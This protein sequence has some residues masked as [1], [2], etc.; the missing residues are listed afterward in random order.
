M[1]KKNSYNVWLDLESQQI[2]PA[3]V[4]PNSLILTV[5]TQSS[6]PTGNW[7]QKPEKNGD[8]YEIIKI[9]DSI[10]NIEVGELEL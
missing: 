8:L 9:P 6:P 4:H 7:P 2:C 1:F 10:P 3:H 5:K